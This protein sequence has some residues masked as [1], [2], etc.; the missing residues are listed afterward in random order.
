MSQPIYQIAKEKEYRK[1]GFRLDTL[2]TPDNHR[3]F[4]SREFL[5]LM[6]NKVSS[7][8]NK[9]CTVPEIEQMDI[10]LKKYPPSKF[11]NG[12]MSNALELLANEFI[13]RYAVEKKIADKNSSTSVVSLTKLNEVTDDPTIDEYQKKEIK[14]F[15]LNENQ[16]KYSAFTDRRGNAVVDKERN[17]GIRSTPDGYPSGHKI[18]INEVNEQNYETLKLVKNF[19]NPDSIDQLVSRFSSSY[20]SFTNVSLPHQIVPLDSKNRL[21]SNTSNNEYSW[22]LNYSTNI[23]QL[24]DIKVQDTIQQVMRM[25][26]ESFWIPLTY[27]NTYYSRIRMLIKEFTIQ[28]IWDSEFVSSDINKSNLY[29]YHFEFN[30][31]Q[32]SGDRAFLE[33]VNKDYTF[34][35]PFAQVNTLTISFRTPFQSLTFDDDRGVYTITYANPTVFTLT[36]G[37]NNN[38][39]TGDLI[40]VINSDSGNT[41]IDQLLNNINGYIIT[42]ISATSFSI[43]VDTSALVGTQTGVDVYYGSK[44]IVVPMRF[45]CLEQ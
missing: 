23:G 27:I 28:S 18:S 7:I 22:N 12:T 16:N 13:N 17:E 34:R 30:I 44:R 32:T 42:K 11:N 37:T 40:Y 35:K 15:T 41:T 24:G 4:I 5:L 10:F 33:P 14:Q 31:T 1:S 21:L 8:T 38:L 29:Y 9:K 39:A 6:A 26:V 43:P 36:S 25:S 19:L 2:V 3:L 45:V 20:L